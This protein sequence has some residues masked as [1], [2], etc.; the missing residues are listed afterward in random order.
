M[1]SIWMF[2]FLPIVFP[3]ID[4]S[5]AFLCQCRCCLGLSC[6]PIDLEIIEISDCDFCQ[7]T[8][9]ATYQHLCA[10]DYAS[11][12]TAFMCATHLSAFLE[13]QQ[14]DREEG[15]TFTPENRPPKSVE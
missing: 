3:N 1:I 9:K 4:L 11:F 8:C 5:S 6:T 14:P 12:H 15:R 2:A 10:P 13:P 7:S